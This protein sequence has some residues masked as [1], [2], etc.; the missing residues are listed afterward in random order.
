[1]HLSP[2][3]QLLKIINMAI[4][5]IEKFMWLKEIS[6]GGDYTITKRYVMDKCEE[7]IS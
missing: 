3:I 1:M 6:K 7:G 5:I 2:I 4:M